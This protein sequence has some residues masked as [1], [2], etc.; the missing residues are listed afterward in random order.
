MHSSP[1]LLAISW[2]LI[3]TAFGPTVAAE[4]DF[5][6]DVQPL[7]A[8][9]CYACHGPDTREAGLRLDDR[10]V[11]TAEL[12]SGATAVVPG[13]ASK[14]ELIARITSRDPELQ[15]PPEG[16]RLSADEVAVIERW[17]A[18]GAEWQAHWAFRPV[19]RPPL[20][21]PRLT[22]VPLPRL[23][24]PLLLGPRLPLHLLLML[25]RPPGPPAPEALLPRVGAAE[26]AAA[27][28][29]QACSA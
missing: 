11:A 24:P 1:A 21:A 12:D 28:C 4:I 22:A 18:A 3:A 5:A 26:T 15:M 25:P 23:F 2:A 17:I 29:P 6:R 7:L 27:S 9:K 13:H 16:P 14:S 19:E 10:T 20:P 8:R